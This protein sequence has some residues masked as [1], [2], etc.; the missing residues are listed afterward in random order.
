MVV[1]EEEGSF[2]RPK[3]DFEQGKVNLGE[4]V[5]FSRQERRVSLQSREME[6]I[7]QRE[8]DVCKAGIRTSVR[9]SLT[10]VLLTKSSSECK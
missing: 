2:L 4:W 5:G 3:E 1:R 9:W 8:W 7:E 10:L 6:W